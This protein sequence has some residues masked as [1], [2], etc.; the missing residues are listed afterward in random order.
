MYTYAIPDEV[1]KKTQEVLDEYRKIMSGEVSAGSI[2]T[3]EDREILNILNKD[4]E[5]RAE[6]EEREPELLVT[7]PAQKTQMTA[8][9]YFMSPYAVYNQ[10][11]HHQGGGPKEVHTEVKVIREKVD[12]KSVE[13]KRIPDL[14]EEDPELTIASALMENQYEKEN[15][16]KQELNLLS[17]KRKRELLQRISREELRDVVFKV[18]KMPYSKLSAAG[19]VQPQKGEKPGRRRYSGKPILVTFR[20][21]RLEVFP[22]IRAASDATGAT[23]QAVS[24]CCKGRQKFAAGCQFE[25][26]DIQDITG[27]LKD[28]VERIEGL[29]DREDGA[30]VEENI[31]LRALEKEVQKVRA[32]GT[33]EERDEVRRKL[34]EELVRLRGADGFGRSFGN[35]N[36]TSQEKEW[37]R[38]LK[39]VLQDMGNFSDEEKEDK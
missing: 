4:E 24:N 2:V 17:N 36:M 16:Y 39:A 26:V 35:S 28:Y 23:P 33:Q 21:G 38:K 11:Q 31:R 10:V 15:H 3:D 34:E 12:P 7:A 32:T 22:S 13:G 37:H 30:D 25:Y 20:D 9:E 29:I 18:M 5:I 14:G 6:K 27:V 8:G 1:Y 19:Y